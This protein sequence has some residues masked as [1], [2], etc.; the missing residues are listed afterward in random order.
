M[1]KTQDLTWTHLF[2]WIGYFASFS[3]YLL[4]FSPFLI[5]ICLLLFLNRFLS[6][7]FIFLFQMCSSQRCAAD[8]LPHSLIICSHWLA[9]SRKHCLHQKWKAPFII[10]WPVL[11]LEPWASSNCFCH[12]PADSFYVAAYLQYLISEAN[13]PPALSAVYTIDW[14]QRLAA[15]PKVSDHL[16]ISVISLFCF[17]F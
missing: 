1:P 12:I 7:L 16:I 17:S 3:L 4:L 10:I 6:V 5:A 14:A 13:S 15:P 8:S 9:V 2:L 11:A